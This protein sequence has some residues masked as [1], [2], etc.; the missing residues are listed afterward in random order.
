MWH[1]TYGEKWSVFSFHSLLLRRSSTTSS[2]YIHSIISH[3]SDRDG[4]KKGLLLDSMWKLRNDFHIKYLQCNRIFFFKILQDSW[5]FPCDYFVKEH[6]NR[7]NFCT[8]HNGIYIESWKVQPLSMLYVVQDKHHQFSHEY[9]CRMRFRIAKQ[10]KRIDRRSSLSK[11]RRL[12][13]ILL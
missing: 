5:I 8:Q 13:L 12:K 7:I 6:S 2:P 3:N 4:I 9:W 10:V 11:A 1:F